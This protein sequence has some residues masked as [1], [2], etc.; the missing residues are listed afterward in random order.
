M[1]DFSNKTCVF[2]GRFQPFHTGQMMVL[3]GMIKLCGKAIVVIGSSNKSDTKED[4]FSW[5]ERREMIQ[6]ALQEKNLIETDVFIVEVPDMIDDAKWIAHV[7]EKVGAFEA[8]WTGNP[9]VRKLCETHGIEVKEIK[10]VPGFNGDEILQM[11]RDD[12]AF[13]DEKVSGSVGAFIK[14]IE[15]HIRVRNLG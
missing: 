13:W 6:R 11:M 14:S 9:D 4:P 12:N 3:E 15:G 7:K 1:T 5:D 10:K 2:I 8:V